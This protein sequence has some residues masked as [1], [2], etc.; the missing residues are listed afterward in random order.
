MMMNKSSEFGAN[1]PN[2]AEAGAHLLFN[3]P[4]LERLFDPRDGGH[5]L[6]EMRLRLETTMHGLE[7]VV[8][9]GT[10]EDARRAG[11][12]IEAYR[13]TLD[14]LAELERRRD[15]AGR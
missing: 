13:A 2:G 5:A 12:I 10:P 15:T 6:T 14:L 8:R 11:A 9:R 1:D 3:Y 4:A 7:R